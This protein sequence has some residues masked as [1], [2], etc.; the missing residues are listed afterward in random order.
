MARATTQPARG[1]RGPFGRRPPISDSEDRPALVP[2]GSSGTTS[3][4]VASE[5][6]ESRR[7]R[8]RGDVRRPDDADGNQVEPSPEKAEAE[9]GATKP[10]RRRGSRGGRRHRRPTETGATQTRQTT[11]ATDQT[12]QPSRRARQPQQPKKAPAESRQPAE[13]KQPRSPLTK[14]RARIPVTGAPTEHV[15]APFAHNAEYEFARILDFYG[16][17]WQY[18]PRSFPLRWE[19]GHVT[20]AFT[21]DFYLPDL[22]LYVELTTLKSSLTAEKNR[23]MRLLKELYPEVNVIMLKKRDYLRLLAKYGYGPLSPD[24]VP[25][26][27]RVL[28]TATKLQQRVGQLGAQI[29]RDYAGKEPVLIGV[30]RGVICFISDLMRHISVPSAVDL[31]AISSY[32]GNG[33]GAVRILKDIDE[34]IKGRDVLLVEDIVDT[35]MTLN[36]VIDYLQT[37]RPASIRVCTLLDKRARRIVNVPLDYVAFEIPDEFVVGYGLD[38]HQ[39]FRNLPFI[40]VL[41]HEL[42]P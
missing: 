6:S 31:M 30:L 12:S 34:N 32:E 26:I 23:K 38:F 39:R 29:S 11:V 2:N 3:R 10:K 8:R 21:P 27:D 40:A 42:L 35:G 20:E 14:A 41:K 5:P 28:I 7:W 33:A 37:K 9:D 36:H 18:E 22:N 1:P 17:D 19:R 24:Q 25:D 13:E 15:P 16:I 4:D